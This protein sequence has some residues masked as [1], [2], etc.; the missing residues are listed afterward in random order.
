MTSE[1]VQSL[2]D[3]EISFAQRL[4][5]GEVG[6]RR[7]ALIKLRK[8]FNSTIS[9]KGVRFV[10][11]LNLKQSSFCRRSWLGRLHATVEGAVLLHVV[12][13]EPIAGMADE[14]HE[15]QRSCQFRI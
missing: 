15:Q 7:K 8:W 5:S 9:L 13:G 10:L 12:A 6:V 4:A 11:C 1:L 2:S 14:Y 3:D